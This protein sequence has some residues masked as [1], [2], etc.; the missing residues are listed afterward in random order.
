MADLQT[1]SL[2]V[3]CNQAKVGTLSEYSNL[4]HFEYH[5]Q[6]NAFD[7]APELPIE[8]GRIEDGASQRPV[9]WFFD[10]LL[11]E[12]NARA[13][14]ARDAKLDQADAFGLLTHYGA[15]SAGALTLL[16]EDE[17]PTTL[18]EHPLPFEELSNRIRHLPHIALSA[19]TSKRMSLAGAQHKLPVIYRD[20]TLFEPKE[21]T[22]STHILKPEHSDPEQYP[23]T[24]INE[25][26]MMQLAK[27]LGLLVPDTWVLHVPEPVY[28][29]ERF[30][31]QSDNGVLY[32]RHVL[33]GCQ[34][35]SLDRT[36]KYQQCT[37]A[38]LERM[39]QLSRTKGRTRQ[40][41]FQWMLFNVLIGNTD[42]HLKNLSFFAGPSAVDLAPHYDLIS[43]ALYEQ[44]GKW[45]DA[46]L[47]WA[48]GSATRLGDVRLADVLAL[49]DALKLSLSYAKR[50]V[51]YMIKQSGDVTGTL[52][53]CLEKENL[54]G[55]GRQGELRH[56]RQFQ[57]G[58]LKDI[59]RQLE[60]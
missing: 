5:P 40:R 55:A 41:L 45:G 16:H 56:L 60:S 13:L 7:L 24:V 36:F 6:W 1:R 21:A 27:G 39:V 51:N 37:L 33:D 58:V 4:W 29:V 3:W 23:H 11:P 14:L 53:E 47:I 52:L 2:T 22:P 46:R 30:D 38:S 28:L 35:L 48:V 57:H 15:E 10:N 43:T 25:W 18:G 50:T 42:D 32:R 12:E 31:R 59:V 17:V 20:G 8:S 26:F 34:L 9:Q 19:G 49:A 54:P 44:P